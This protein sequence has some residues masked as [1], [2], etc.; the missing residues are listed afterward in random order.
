[1]SFRR[2]ESAILITH[3]L[4]YTLLYTLKLYINHVL[5]LKLYV[6][7]VLKSQVTIFKRMNWC[8]NVCINI[9]GA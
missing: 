4:L 8:V 9:I 2:K 1:M 7:H 3:T 6:N 5:T